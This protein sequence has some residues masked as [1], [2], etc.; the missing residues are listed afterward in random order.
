MEAAALAG[1]RFVVLDRPNPI[2]GRRA[3]GPVLHPEYA[4]FVGRAPIAQQHGMTVGELAELFNAEFLPERPSGPVELSVQWLRGW[5]REL[6]YDRTGLPWVLPSPNLPSLETAYVYPGSCLFSG[7]NLSQG[8]GTTRPFQLVG[9]PFIDHRWAAELTARRLPGLA[10]RE[11][12]FTPTFSTYQGKNCGG[13]DINV[14]DQAKVDAVALGIALLVT[15]KSLYPRDFAWLNSGTDAKPQ[16]WIDHL[17]GSDRVRLAVDA[18][19][20][21]DAIVAGWQ[22]DLAR[23]NGLRRRFLHY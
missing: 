8:R 1:K 9:A 13:V 23:F 16:W 20:D 12:Y 11:A 21:V 15:L 6:S 10:F 22:D 19:D 14:T 4:T 2:T 5:R 17:T 18:G 7:T 3:T